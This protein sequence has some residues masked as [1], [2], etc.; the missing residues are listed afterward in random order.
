MKRALSIILFFAALCLV[1]TQ[2]YAQCPLNISTGEEYGYFVYTISVDTSP[3]DVVSFGFDMTYNA[4]EMTYAFTYTDATCLTG[5]SAGFP[6]PGSA[7]WNIG[8]NDLGGGVV[9]AGGYVI[10]PASNLWVTGASGCVVKI[11]FTKEAGAP[12]VPQVCLTELVDGI[13]GWCDGCDCCYPAAPLECDLLLLN[14]IVVTP[15]AG[16]FIEIYNPNDFNVDLSNVYLTDATYASGSQYY[17]HIAGVCTPAGT[18]GGGSYSDFHA[19]FPEG[20]IIGPKQV[21]TVAMDGTAFVTTYGMQPTYELWDTDPAIADMREAFT[22]SINNQGGLTNSGEVVVMY[23]WDGLSPLVQD[24]DYAVWGD[25]AEAVDKTGIVCGAASYLPDTPIAAQDILDTGSHSSSNSWQR[26]DYLEGVE[27]KTGGN[28]AQGHDETSEDLSVTW[29]ED[30]ATPNAESDCI[31][32]IVLKSLEAQAGNGSVTIVWSTSAEIDN[33]GFNI[34]RAEE[35][36]E[37]VKVNDAL[38]PAKGAAAQGAVYT[39]VDDGVQNRVTYS[40]KLED[41]D[42]NGVKTMHGPV[43]ATPRIINAVK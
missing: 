18:P 4:S 19:I 16:E 3:S 9:R 20:A 7:V 14:E 42:L 22:G 26:C 35:D 5:N 41:V 6:P 28:G 11:A 10:Q 24:L 29:V 30:V 12:D 33:A 8:G 2:A 37:M 25:K 39:F 21:Q 31:T 27:I 17:Y 32:L 36:G 15:T 23:C 34:Y 13:A 43:S 40:Y 1:S 38:I